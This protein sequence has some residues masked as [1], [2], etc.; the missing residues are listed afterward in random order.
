MY[1]YNNSAVNFTRER[2]AAAAAERLCVQAAGLLTSAIAV[3]DALSYAIERN[4]YVEPMD[5]RAI[6]RALEPT[7]A[8]SRAAWAVDLGFIGRNASVT[9]RRQL[10]N[11]SDAAMIVQSD[12]P[13]CRSALG[14]LGCLSADTVPAKAQH[15]YTL[16]LALPGGQEL[17][18]DYRVGAITEANSAF[19][20]M[21]GPSFVALDPN[22]TSP[23]LAGGSSQNHVPWEAAYSLVFRIL[24]PGSAGTASL[25]GRILLKLTPLRQ[26]ELLSDPRLGEQGFLFVCDDSGALL[27][28]SKPGYQVVREAP[29]GTVRFRR[30]WEL[31]FPWASHLQEADFQ[32]GHRSFDAEG[33]HVAVAPVRGRGM[34]RFYALVV[35]EKTAFVDNGFGAMSIVS[36][37]LALLPYPVGY[38]IYLAYR[39]YNWYK[40]RRH[41]K[42]VSPWG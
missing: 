1:M 22:V 37:V 14:K 17:E 15:W 27:A 30:A 39:S 4:L 13:D 41:L 19:T 34:E 29:T 36:Q 7:F 21:D 24:F 6:A 10:S 33:F 35:A 12:A 8:A 16:A 23:F 20:W 31:D 18:Q 32:G 42:R 38:L 28:A 5:Y 3:R 25:V 9:V 26:P 2:Y 40:E 11:V